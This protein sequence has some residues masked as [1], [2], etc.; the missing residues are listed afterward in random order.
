M[1][2][3]ALP[4]LLSAS[5]WRL[6]SPPSRVFGKLRGHFQLFLCRLRAMLEARPCRKPV[7]V[8]WEREDGVCPCQALG[9]D[10]AEP[11]PD[12]VPCSQPW[13]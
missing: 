13:A 1:Q 5:S 11:L 7:P 6:M 12:P 3:H 4:P 2:L 8:S 9:G 10:S